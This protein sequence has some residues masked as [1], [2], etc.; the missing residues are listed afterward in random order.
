M[1]NVV[2]RQSPDRAIILHNETC[3]YCGTALTRDTRTKEHVIGRR[4]VPRGSLHQHWNLIVWACEPC[5]RRKAE[6]EDDISAISMQ[7]DPWGAHARDDIRLR[8]EAERKAKTKSRRS[9]KP[10]KD[11]HEQFSISHTFGGAELTFSFTSAPQADETRIIELVRM[12]VMAFFYWITIQPG[13]VNGRFCQG[14]FFPLQPV[15]RADWGNEQ[16]RFFMAETK[17]WDLRIHAVTADGYFKLAIKKHIDE[18]I[19]SFAVEWNESYR[20]VGFFGDTAGLIKLRDRL[21][22][23]AMQTIHTKGD[24]WVRHRREVPLSD[25]DDTLFDPPADAIDQSA[26]GE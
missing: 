19:W 14:S 26:A 11:S 24:D 8:N 12:Q 7:P 20:I 21:P 6:L 3:P 2:L 22:K 17:G 15:R 10:V 1:S 9:G 5:N 13:E 23:L 4:F 18:L 16:L 25:Q